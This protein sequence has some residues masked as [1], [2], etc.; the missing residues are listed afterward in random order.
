LPSALNST[1]M[2]RVSEYSSEVN[3]SDDSWVPNDDCVRRE[4]YRT[5]QTDSSSVPNVDV[6]RGGSIKAALR[7]AGLRPTRQRL[8]L[9]RLLFHKGMRHLTPEMVYEEARLANV[10]VSLATVY[11][12]LN[13]LTD[14]GLLRRISID[15]NKNYFDNNVGEHQHF[16]LENSYELLD[17]SGQHLLLQKMPEVPLGYEV[18]RIDMVVRLRKQR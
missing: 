17:I 9:Y 5:P 16:Y 1:A 18:V 4:G 12:T 13:Q 6:V 10:T 3:V 8:S 15:G 7:G 14:A 11:N 2:G